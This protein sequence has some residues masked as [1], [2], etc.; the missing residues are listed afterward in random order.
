MNVTPITCVGRDQIQRTFE[1]S[2]EKT[3]FE[4]QWRFIVRCIPALKSRE[5]FEATIEVI[6]DSTARVAVIVA[7]SSEYRVVGIPD[8]LLPLAAN[9]LNRRIV[10]SSN[11]SGRP[12]ERRSDQATGMWERFRQDGRA[13][14]DA[15]TDV[16]TFT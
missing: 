14:Y 2:Y 11:K 13:S 7:N 3:P 9:L 8:A 15:T 6:D 12:S 16:Y 10:S 4:E 5:F 1:L